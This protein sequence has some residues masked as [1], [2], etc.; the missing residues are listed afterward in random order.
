MK[1]LRESSIRKRRL[2][3]EWRFY[4]QSDHHGFLLVRTELPPG[5]VQNEHSHEQFIEIHLLVSGEVEVTERVDGEL[6]S[7]RLGPGDVVLLDPP[8]SHNMVNPGPEPAVTLTW[9]VLR[10][11][12]S[13]EEF[14]RLGREDWFGYSVQRTDPAS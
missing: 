6:K 4:Y 12:V 1:I 13:P 14:E 8:H 11:E 7:E 5:R 9:K 2:D 3:D 10:P